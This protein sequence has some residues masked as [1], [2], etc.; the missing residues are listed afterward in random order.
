MK[1]INARQKRFIDAY[2][3]TGNG[4]KAAVAA[5]YSENTARKQASR[6]L[7]SPAFAHV[8]QEILDRQAAIKL[9]S[10]VTRD[11]KRQALWD[12]VQQCRKLVPVDAESDLRVMLNAKGLISA[13]SELNRMDGD[14]APQKT[15]Q[16]HTV[17]VLDEVF[18]EIQQHRA[19]LPHIPED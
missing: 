4:S 18:T 1:K 13:I 19:G 7:N 5:G 3:E 10:G 2:L 16:S 15:E 11:A 6:L 14:H 17:D 8:Q 12:T 9:V